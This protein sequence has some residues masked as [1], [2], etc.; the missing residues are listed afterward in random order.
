MFYPIR[1]VVVSMIM[2]SFLAVYPGGLAADDSA[3]PFVPGEKLTFDLKWGGVGAG[4]AVLQV[5]PMTTLNG[6][7]AYRFEVTARTNKGIDRI[8]KIR[9]RLESFADINMIHSLLYKQKIREGEYRKDRV[10]TFDWKKN[11]LEYIS[12]K[13]TP[14]Y[15]PIM[16][17]TFDP[18]AA[19][20]FLRLQPFQVSAKIECP[21][22]DGKINVIGRV[23]ILRREKVQVG[24]TTYDTYVLEP[25]MDDVELFSSN[26][27]SNIRVWVTADPRRIPVLVKSR[28]TFGTFKAELRKIERVP[29]P[30]IPAEK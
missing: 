21:I 22:T 28:V 1:V 18:L 15:V 8:F 12:N 14:K 3:R 11:E 17:G 30:Q 4:K 16:P 27:D 24:D 2:G 25:I 29:V 5:L 23:N 26:A 7:E 19:F 9:D 13:G 20:Y 10:I 6:V